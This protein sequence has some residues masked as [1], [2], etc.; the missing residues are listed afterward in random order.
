MPRWEVYPTCAIGLHGIVFSPYSAHKMNQSD[1]L[2]AALHTALSAPPFEADLSPEEIRRALEVPKDRAHGDLAFPCFLLARQL[3]K[4]PPAIAAELA[5]QLDLGPSISDARAI[6]PYLNFVLNKASLAAELI[7][8][9]LDGSFLARRPCVDEKIMIEYSQPNTHKALH[10]GHTRCAAMGDSLVRI[11]EWL[12]HEVVAVNY[13]GDEGTHVARCLWYYLNYFNGEVPTKNRGEFLGVLYNKATELAELSSLTEAPY[14]G[15]TVARVSRIQAHLQSAESERSSVAAK[16]RSG[17]WQ[18]V[19]LETA[20]GLKAVICAGEG[21]QVGDLVPWAQPHTR[22]ADRTVGI[23]EKGGIISEGMIC[24]GAEIGV[25]DESENI[26]VLDPDLPLGTELAEVYRHGDTPVLPQFEQRS[27]EIGEVLMKLETGDPEMHR[28]WQETRDWS[29][30]DFHDAYKYLNCRF[31]HDFFESEFGEPSKK[32]VREAQARGVFVESEGAV[33]ADLSAD[34]LGFS[35]LIKSNGT[36]TYASRDLTLAA[37]KFDDFEVDRSVYVVDSAQSLHFQQVFKCLE[38][39]G[40][41]Q[42]TNCYHHA[43]AQVVLRG[44][45]GSPVKMSSR[46]GNVILF[47][48]LKEGLE[49]RLRENFLDMFRGDWPDEEIDRAARYLACASIRYGMLKQT[50]E[51]LILFDLAE[52]TRPE[53][54]NGPYLMYAYARI[55]SILRKADELPDPAVVDWAVLTADEESVLIAHLT[56]FPEVVERAGRDYATHLICNYVYELCRSIS[57]FYRECPVLK[58][59]TPET[60]AAR[61]CLVLATGK[62][63][64]QGLELLGI[65]PLDRM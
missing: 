37:R 49:S 36:A 11:F 41:E 57:R 40:F 58:A 32:L 33:G 27:A 48:A 3:R 26:L 9:I 35:I 65:Q 21:F 15:V 13:L 16:T 63:L 59:E 18:I 44:E 34:G 17:N 30:Q 51:S 60:R 31:D 2:A 1:E 38:K 53:G 52:W 54:D 28:I 12:G 5:D 6:G 20:D 43:Y 10:V 47:T 42:A 29:L 14:P 4:A 22:V 19:D 56:R 8:G 61:L 39:M 50:N 46:K 24:T 7:P 64:K 55:Q 23:V 62:T 25:N 45:D